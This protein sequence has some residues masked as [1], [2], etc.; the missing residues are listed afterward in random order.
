MNDWRVIVSGPADPVNNMAVD[1]A[2]FAEYELRRQPVLRL[3]GW[4]PAGIS[5]GVNQRE[6][7]AVYVECCRESGVPV[8]KRVTGGNAIFHDDELTY[9]VVCSVEDIGRP[10]GIKESY[11]RLCSPIV[12]FYESLG[13]RA[14]FS[15]DDPRYL[16]FRRKSAFCFAAWEEYD[17]LVNGRKIGGNAQKRRR[18]VILQHGSIPL[19]LDFD[20]IRFFCRGVPDNAE[21]S[22]TSLNELTRRRW[23]WTEAKESLLIAF[24]DMFRNRTEPTD[25]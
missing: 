18:D 4:N 23:T 14:C 9:C 7:D 15:R 2:L 13:L 11:R 19:S 1:E 20:R 3:Y 16:D 6:D 8:V 5:I 21:G 24:L 17:I 22:I 10:Q 12:A 25:V